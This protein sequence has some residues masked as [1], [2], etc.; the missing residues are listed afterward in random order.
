M[1]LSAIVHQGMF[2][3][4]E[5]FKNDSSL[6]SA[7]VYSKLSMYDIGLAWVTIG[8]GSFLIIS[9][10]IRYSLLSDGTIDPKTKKKI[11]NPNRSTGQ[12]IRSILTCAISLMSIISITM[13]LSPD[14]KFSSLKT[15]YLSWIQVMPWICIIFVIL[16]QLYS[17]YKLEQDIK[18]EA[19]EIVQKCD[20]FDTYFDAEI[21]KNPKWTSKQQTNLIAE[22]DMLKKI[23]NQYAKCLQIRDT[24]LGGEP[25][26]IQKYVLKVCHPKGD[27]YRNYNTDSKKSEKAVICRYLPYNCDADAALYKI[28]EVP[29][30]CPKNLYGPVVP[31]NQQPSS[32]DLDT[33]QK[34][35]F[36][37]K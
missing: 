13:V 7:T 26:K 29:E 17:N 23:R 24:Q 33:V 8:V 32:N 9:T 5:K 1:L 27:E 12:I 14:T 10:V 34:L 6:S 2:S 28:P 30:E 35:F 4:I 37:A 19:K 25:E 15:D 18:E 16:E 36:P 20:T 3:T 31:V 22:K 21:Q 11:D